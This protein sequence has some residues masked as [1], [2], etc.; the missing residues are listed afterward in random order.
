VSDHQ[1]VPQ[2]DMEELAWGN[3]I[4]ATLRGIQARIR[5]KLDA[6]TA[7]HAGRLTEAQRYSGVAL[8][9]LRD[10]I[11]AVGTLALVLAQGKP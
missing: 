3:E 11:P 1:A 5:A 4:I 8:G 10:A 6:V 7:D 2:P 9:L